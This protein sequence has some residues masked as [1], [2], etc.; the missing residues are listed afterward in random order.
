MT[1]SERDTG[2]Q[3][4][5]H[6]DSAR[7]GIPGGNDVEPQRTESDRGQVSASA[8]EVYEEFFVPALFTEW[9]PMLA[10]A[11]GI[12]PSYRVLDVGCGTGVVTRAVAGL[13][14]DSGA[15]L[16]IDINDGMLDVA[17]RRSPEIDWRLGSVEALP[18]DDQ[19]FDAV[20][21]QFGLMFF[22]DQPA[23]IREMV[24]V[25]RPGGRL[26]VAVWDVLD[27]VPGYA[28]VT[29]LLQR[30]FGDEAANAMRAPYLL[31]NRDT[32]RSVF[33][34]AGIADV[35]IRTHAGTA[36]FPSIESWVH[37]DIKGWTLADIINDDQ[38]AQLLGEARSALQRYVIGDGTV[39]FSQSAHIASAVKP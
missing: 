6:G 23:A 4:S 16:G 27:N 36:R 38:Y 32:L 29:E 5:V 7:S 1:K 13:L 37:T 17:R 14:D 2:E 33:Q 34:R 19:S 21:C 35:D 20:V 18:F 39:A 11:A 3:C 12:D 25:L 30:L 22:E 15:V 31:G 9:S 24:R 8:A 28:S 10:E 26:A